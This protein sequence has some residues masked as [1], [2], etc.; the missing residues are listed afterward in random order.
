VIAGIGASLQGRG[1]ASSVLGLLLG[2]FGLSFPVLSYL[3]VIARS[4]G[5]PL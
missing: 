3:N 1:R 4:F 2:V 5:S